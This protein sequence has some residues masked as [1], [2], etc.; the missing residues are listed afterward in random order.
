MKL[1]AFFFEKVRREIPTVV[2]DAEIFEGEC[3]DKG[4][5]NS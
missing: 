2:P 5:E 3:S 1:C 4:E